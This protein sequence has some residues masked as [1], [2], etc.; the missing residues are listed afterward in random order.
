[1]LMLF[2]SSTSLEG[3]K[4]RRGFVVDSSIRERGRFLYSE[5]SRG[6]VHCLHLLCGMSV[7]AVG[8]GVPAP[9]PPTKL[10]CY[11]SLSAFVESRSISAATNS[12]W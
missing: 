12:V 2:A 3:S 4:V 6:G 1:M 8:G 9:P 11:S 7:V 5:C 10:C